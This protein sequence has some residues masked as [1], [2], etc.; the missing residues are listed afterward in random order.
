MTPHLS[1]ILCTYNRADSLRD[2]LQALAMQQAREGLSMEVVVADNNSTDET[3]H[4][5]EAQASRWPVRYLFEGCLGKSH[6]LNHGI[7]AAQAP[8]LAFTDDDVIPEPSWAQAL[9]D[10]GRALNADCVGG[11]TLPLWAPEPPRGVTSPP[12]PPFSP[13]PLHS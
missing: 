4:V 1:I 2:T 9:Y 11:R 5:V 10:A 13:S 12:P 7:S 3:R 8:W 6:A